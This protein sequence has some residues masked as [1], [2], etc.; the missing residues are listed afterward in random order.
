LWARSHAAAELPVARLS[1]ARTGGA[2]RPDDLN[3][4]ERLGK[5]QH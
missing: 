1:T 4:S 3:G 2:D 5:L